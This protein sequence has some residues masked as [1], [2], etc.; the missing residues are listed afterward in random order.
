MTDAKITKVLLSLHGF[1]SSPSSLKAQQMREYL[2]VTHP[3]IHFVCPQLPVL[4]KDMW[5]VVETIFKQYEG[6]DI[7]VMGSSLGGFL[8]TKAAQQYGVK[9]LL[10]NPAVTPDIL[11]TERYKGE[12]THPYLQQQYTINHD[13]IQQLTALNVDVV[14]NPDNIWV[15]LQQQDEVLDYREA[16]KK[17]QGCKVTCESGGDHS[18]IGFERYLEQIIHFLY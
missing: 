12:Q 18:F 16:V 8:A 9:V 10:I 3:D 7:A 1:H 17:Y 11:L 15:L 6:C 4:P 2:L 14:N 5:V 13:Y